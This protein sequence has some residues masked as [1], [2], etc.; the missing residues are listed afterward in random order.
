MEKKEM[1]MEESRM[2]GYSSPGCCNWQSKQYCEH[3][4]V[5][6]G[7]RTGLIQLQDYQSPKC[8]VVAERTSESKT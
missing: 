4:V 5:F 3:L 8:R 1:K 2:E 7:V 6:E